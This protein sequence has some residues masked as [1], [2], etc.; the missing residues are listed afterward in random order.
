MLLSACAG[1]PAVIVDPRP[2]CAAVKPVCIDRDDVLNE[3][4][5]SQIE[6]NNLGRASVCG[7]PPKCRRPS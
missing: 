4:T 7:R 5:A 1:P 6:A 2:F 3:G